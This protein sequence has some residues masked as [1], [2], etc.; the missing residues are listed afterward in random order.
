MDR[1]ASPEIQQ[2]SE[3]IEVANKDG[4]FTP[5]LALKTWKGAQNQILAGCVRSLGF[6][7]SQGTIRLTWCC[8][9]LENS[10]KRDF[11]IVNST[12]SGYQITLGLEASEKAADAKRGR[13]AFP[14]FSRR[15]TRGK[16]SPLD[17][18][19]LC[20]TDLWLRQRR[21]DDE[22]RRELPTRFAETERRKR[23]IERTWRKSRRRGSSSPDCKDS[24]L[25]RVVCDGFVVCGMEKRHAHRMEAPCRRRL[26][27]LIGVAGIAFRPTWSW[28]LLGRQLANLTIISSLVC[29]IELT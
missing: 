20:M 12:E 8:K 6:P 16:Q 17:Q 22:R 14:A 3:N 1:E 2:T 18:S 9:G 23:K 21:G 19:T 24:S 10:W 4:I 13:K 25:D 11:Q 15:Q 27:F 7:N 28:T 29:Y 26:P 5:V